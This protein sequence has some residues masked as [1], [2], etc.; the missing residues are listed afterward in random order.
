[1]Q[2]GMDSGRNGFIADLSRI[3]HANACLNVKGWWQFPSFRLFWFST[4]IL[5]A[6][7]CPNSISDVWAVQAFPNSDAMFTTSSDVIQRS[8]H[9]ICNVQL[10]REAFYL[11]IHIVPS[12]SCVSVC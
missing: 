3:I 11:D 5:Q 4:L 12:F 1:M 6:G 10:Q 8:C 2:C 9:S 7:W